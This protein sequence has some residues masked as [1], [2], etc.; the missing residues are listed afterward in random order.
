VVAYIGVD[1]PSGVQKINVPN[2]RQ[3]LQGVFIEGVQ[4]GWPQDDLIENIPK[5]V[6]GLG[7]RV[8]VSAIRLYGQKVFWG[9]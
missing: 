7:G 4:H 9:K 5:V 2:L 3:H 8:K 1:H 6:N